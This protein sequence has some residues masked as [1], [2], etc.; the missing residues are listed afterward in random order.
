MSN[1]IARTSVVSSAEFVEREAYAK[2]TL[3]LV[4]LLF[5]SYVVAFLDRINVGFA[6]LQ[7]LS[8]L[9]FSEVTYGLGAGIFFLGYVLCEVPSNII[10]HRVGARRWISRIMI[11]WGLLSA[12]TMFVKTPAMFYGLR[13]LLGVAEAGFL[14][15]IVLYMTY[16]YPAHRRGKIMA[17]FFAAVPA[18]GLIGGPLSGWILESLSGV[19]GLAGWQW[20]FVL[21]ALPSIVLGVVVLTVLP[22]R[23]QDASWLLPKAKKI[24]TENIEADAHDKHE[25]KLRKI[26]S[27]SRVLTLAGIYFCATTGGYGIS[28]WL[29]SIVKATGVVSP[30]DIGLLTAIPFLSAIACMVFISRSADALRERKWHLVGTMSI[31]V[32]GLVCSIHFGSSTV[33][34]IV[35]LSIAA[36]GVYSAFPIFWSLPTAF[37][38]GVG[39]A[40][41]IAFITSV[42]NIGGFV[43]S[44]LIGWV[45][46][47]SGSTDLAMLMLAGIYVVGVV[48]TL[49]VPAR[50]VNK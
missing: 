13:F 32:A 43:S 9:H 42:G 23:I 36:V 24:L 44:Y 30:L 33:G 4:P 48:L 21:E 20:L 34:S 11:T 8:D 38:T 12:A 41:A 40:A 39:A 45:K 28:F 50:L 1:S 15:G 7:M 5:L 47:F 19:H 14:P 18:S 46:Q 35:A 2:V 31:G 16:W 22:D 25:I 10:Q 37:L 6:K 26:F 3:R 27:D 49:T 17:L 29:P